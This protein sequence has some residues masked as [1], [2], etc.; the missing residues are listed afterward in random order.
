MRFRLIID[1]HSNFKFETLD[2]PHIKWKIFHMLS[3]WTAKK[4]DL[5]IVTNEYLAELISELGGKPFVLQDKLPDMDAEYARREP[6][7]ILQSDK[8]KVMFVTTFSDDE[9]I[10]EILRSKEF[11]PDTI[12]YITGKYSKSIDEVEREK[13]FE[14]NIVL[15]GFISD[16]DYFNLM[17]IVDLVVVL[18]VKDNLLTCGAY[19]AISMEKPLVLSDTEALKNYFSQGAVYVAP[20]GKSIATGVEDAL[21]KLQALEA[22]IQRFVPLMMENWNAQFLE[23]EK[24]V[25][26]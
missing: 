12:Y 10:D 25:N 26:V 18:T 9:P 16:E 22:D 8:P 7:F 11:A 23:L 1:R 24:R 19:E 5:T 6:D 17:R 14:E 21:T 3:R 15:T 13:L 2:L 4:A 20:N